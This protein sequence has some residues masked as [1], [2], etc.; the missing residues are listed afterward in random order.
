LEQQLEA[1]KRIQKLKDKCG[2][3]TPQKAILKSLPDY[4]RIQWVFFVNERDIQFPNLKM[5]LDWINIQ[6]IG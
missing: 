2:A 1:Q 4:L 5:F 6:I 3:D